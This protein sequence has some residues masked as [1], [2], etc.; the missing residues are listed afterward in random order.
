MMTDKRGHPFYQAQWLLA[1]AI[2]TP[3]PLPS[4]AALPTW[5][6]LIYP[7]QVSEEGL[8]LHGSQVSGHLAK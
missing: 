6:W 4:T 8:W 2:L 7:Q 3:S 1:S 5:C